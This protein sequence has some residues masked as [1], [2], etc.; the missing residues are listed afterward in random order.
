MNS[1]GDGLYTNVAGG[2]AQTQ[3]RSR[4]ASTPP[5]LGTAGRL[6]HAP[7]ALPEV[8][9]V[10]PSRRGFRVGLHVPRSVC[11]PLCIGPDLT[12]VTALPALAAVAPSLRL[13]VVR[14]LPPHDLLSP[15]PT[16]QHRLD[17]RAQGRD[18]PAAALLPPGARQGDVALLAPELEAEPRHMAPPLAP[19]LDPDFERPLVRDE[20]LL[21]RWRCAA[22]LAKSHLV[23]P[24]PVGL[25]IFVAPAILHQLPAL[26]PIC[27]VLPVVVGCPA[28]VVLLKPV[29][30]HAPL[31]PVQPTTVAKGLAAQARHAV[32][33]GASTDQPMAAGARLRDLRHRCPQ[34]C[35]RF[36]PIKVLRS[37]AGHSVHVSGVKGALLPRLLIPV[38]LVDN[39]RTSLP[40]KSPGAHK[41]HA[42]TSCVERRP[43]RG[44]SWAVDDQLVIFHLRL[45]VRYVA[46]TASRVATP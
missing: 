36:D 37:V 12:G 42:Q 41:Q 19:Y 13:V 2:G 6:C 15:L 5:Q 22:R 40:F 30:A 27:V 32:T 3:A 46:F 25:P 18:V 23:M 17:L 20:R 7:R 21:H 10:L 11:H 39:A 24:P 28:L 16:R 38:T 43:A 29:L 1:R 14:S 35:V 9:L 33:P 4:P 45:D 8:P 26:Q 31:K 44:V 34:T